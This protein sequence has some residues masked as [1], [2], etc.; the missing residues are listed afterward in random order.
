MAQVTL[1]NEP[2]SQLIYMNL[3]N[4][5]AYFP[6]ETLFLFAF[7]STTVSLKRVKLY[8]M[9]TVVKLQ[10]C[11][12][13]IWGKF[14]LFFFFWSF[15]FS[16]CLKYLAEIHIKTKF[17]FLSSHSLYLNLAFLSFCSVLWTLYN[18]FYISMKSVAPSGQG[19]WPVHICVS[20]Y[21]SH[22]SFYRIQ[23]PLN[24]W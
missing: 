6:I 1:S 20:K 15:C 10:H 18:L 11:E 21:T 5:L 17:S 4:R 22:M 3:I 16:N 2:I 9:H 24:V 14:S 8:S 13:R 19:L 23:G 12:V 7:H